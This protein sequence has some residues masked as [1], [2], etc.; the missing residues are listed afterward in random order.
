METRLKLWIV[1]PRNER[2]FRDLRTRGKILRS[3][4]RFHEV[5]AEC[6]VEDRIRIAIGAIRNIGGLFVTLGLNLSHCG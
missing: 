1:G 2:F 4:H 3:F 5:A 6:N